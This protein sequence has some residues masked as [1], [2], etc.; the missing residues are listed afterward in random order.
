MPTTRLAGLALGIA[1]LIV[2]IAA[3]AMADFFYYRDSQGKL[4]LTNVWSRIPPAYRAQA[5]RNRRPDGKPSGQAEQPR[6]KPRPERVAP[7]QPTV[8]PARVERPKASAAQ[9]SPVDVREF[10]LLHTHMSEFEVLRRLG[11]PAAI[12][13][14]GDLVPRFQHLGRTIRTV[15]AQIWYYP[16]TS[17]TPATRLEFHNGLL[18]HKVR[19]PR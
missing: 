13:D 3:P 6:V 18:M 5:D 1:L 10:G 2:W 11:P 16:G 8:A 4:H 15:Q 17:R 14:I 9:A 19:E 12:N 7:I